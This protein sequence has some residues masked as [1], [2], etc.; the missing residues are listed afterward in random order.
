[1][2]PS[3]SLPSALSPRQS[4]A[5]LAAI[6]VGVAVLILMALDTTVV[7]IGSA[8][9]ARDDGFNPEQY[10]QSQFPAIRSHV[11]ERAVSAATLAS[12]IA[13]D[14]TAAGQEYG[15]PAGIGPIMP[16]TFTGVAGEG[17]SGIYPVT[18]D[19]VPG[20]VTVRVQ[21][22]P[23]IN[24]T[25]LRDATGEIEFG[26]FTNQIEYQNA[27]AAINNAM[28]ADVLANVDTD[29]LA[30]KTVTVTGVFKLINPNNWLVTPVGMDVQ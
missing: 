8:Q 11:E 25:D 9:D 16:V 24:G 27:G 18:V 29:S 6:V 14:Q 12:A 3:A 30:G 19:G 1:M 26:Q 20:K 10:G 22:G 17:K 4:P 28:K 21:T 5:R 23:A 13:E 2:N 15:T 7:E